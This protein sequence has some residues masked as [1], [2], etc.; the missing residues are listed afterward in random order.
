M[1]NANEIINK[2]LIENTMK[3]NIYYQGH[4]EK[5]EINVIGG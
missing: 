5:I 1:K 3:V 4:K 2:G